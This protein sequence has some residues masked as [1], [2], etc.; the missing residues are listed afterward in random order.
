MHKEG[1]SISQYST[2]EL[3]AMGLNSA[4]NGELGEDTFKKVNSVDFNFRSLCISLNKRKIKGHKIMSNYKF[5]KISDGL[6][7]NEIVQIFE[8]MKKNYEDK[9]MQIHEDREN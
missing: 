4:R 6:V 1:D 7:K 5:L 9:L 8:E 2:S 3:I